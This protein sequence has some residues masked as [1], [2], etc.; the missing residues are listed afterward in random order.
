MTYE[1]KFAALSALGGWNTAL[2]MRMPGNWYLSSGIEIGGDGFLRSTGPT[3]ATPQQAIEKA[4]QD[5][6]TDLPYDRYLVVH[7]NG[8]ERCVRW[9][10]YMWADQEIPAIA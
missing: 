9:N 1:E 4:W 10:G 3:G 5:Y 8:N 7:A 2:R 6:V